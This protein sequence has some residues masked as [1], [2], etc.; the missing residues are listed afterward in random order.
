MSKLEEMPICPVCGDETN[1]FYVSDNE[2]V[3]CP[4]CVKLT[5]AWEWTEE[6]KLSR[7]ID[8]YYD[9]RKDEGF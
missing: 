5:D 4:Q 7:A 2:I 3:G 1:D 6:E 8:Y 9:R